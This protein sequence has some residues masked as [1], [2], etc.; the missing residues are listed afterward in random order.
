[1]STTQ[2]ETTEDFAQLNEQLIAYYEQCAKQ[3][4]RNGPRAKLTEPLYRSLSA[5]APELCDDTAL[6]QSR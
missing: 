3:S 5:P 1:M 2:P 6:R 4:R